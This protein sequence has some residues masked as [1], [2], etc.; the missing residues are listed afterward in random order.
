MTKPKI[1]EKLSA[2]IADLSGYSATHAEYCEDFIRIYADITTH[3]ACC[4][5]CHSPRLIRYGGRRE[6]IFDIPGGVFGDTPVKIII[7]RKRHKCKDCD[8]SFH[9]A[10][11]H[12][13]YK[14]RMT[15]R[16]VEYV[17]S[18]LERDTFFNISIDT[19]LCDKTVRNIWADSKA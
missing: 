2:H 5:L 12:R 8:A 14:R 15:A 3:T 17:E 6:P 19:G 18:A 4:P 9:E 13:H 10:D 16:L 11:P 7:Y 1:N